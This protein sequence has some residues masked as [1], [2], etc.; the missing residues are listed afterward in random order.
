MLRLSFA[1]LHRDVMTAR[2]AIDNL[3]IDYAARNA[4]SEF[5]DP[6]LRTAGEIVL[7]MPTHI[8]PFTDRLEELKKR[9]KP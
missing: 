6:H 2:T 5:C 4:W 8:A 9:L 7:R 3:V 1:P